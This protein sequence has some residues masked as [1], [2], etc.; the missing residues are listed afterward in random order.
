MECGLAGRP[1]TA[2]GL[3]PPYPTGRELAVHPVMAERARATSDLRTTIDWL[4]GH[5]APAGR[6]RPDHAPPAGPGSRCSRY[7]RRRRPWRRPACSSSTPTPSYREPAR[8]RPPPAHPGAPAALGV[9]D[10]AGGRRP[11]RTGPAG[12]RGLG[13]ARLPGLGPVPPAGHH[14]RGPDAAGG[15]TGAR[16]RWPRRAGPGIVGRQLQRTPI[17]GPRPAP[18][19]LPPTRTVAGGLTVTN[20]GTVAETGVAVT[21][22]LTPSIRPAPP[23]LRPAERG[24]TTQT[25][26]PSARVLRR[27]LPAP[28]AR[29]RRPLTT[30][31]V[32]VAVPPQANPAGATQQFLLQISGE[33][34]G[35]RPDGG[36]CP[37]RAL[38]R[39]RFDCPPVG[40]GRRMSI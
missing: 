16:R 37:G 39:P 13:P 26:S 33:R 8:L 15:P 32:S 17:G 21:Q 5:G 31:T 3:V 27:P 1:S 24:G 18:A 29:G 28:A 4:S 2:A 9:G 11:A 10:R 22:T 7:P 34:L 36:R 19:V 23:P 20:C 30:L 12:R 25:R 35:L 14:R 40:Q 6:R 38:R